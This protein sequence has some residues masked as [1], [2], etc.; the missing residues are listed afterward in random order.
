[1]NLLHEILHK[2]NVMRTRILLKFEPKTF[3]QLRLWCIVNRATDL[4]Y[5]I[6]YLFQYLPHSLIWYN[7]LFRDRLLKVREIERDCVVC[8]KAFIVKIDSQTK[9]ILTKCFYGGIIRRGIGMWAKYR[10]DENPDGSIKWIRIISRWKELKYRL[11]DLKRLILHQYVDAEYW[12]C[13]D[14]YNKG[15][16]EADE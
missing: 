8:G 13:T 12:E 1:M 4:S 3:G 15:K 14:C 2:I 5:L 11:I 6:N 16:V 7:T 10:M 9:K